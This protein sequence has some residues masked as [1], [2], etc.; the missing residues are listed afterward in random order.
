MVKLPSHKSNQKLM[1]ISKTKLLLIVTGS[2]LVGMAIVIVGA[3]TWLFL[4]FNAGN[5]ATLSFGGREEKTVD[6]APLVSEP[7]T[8]LGSQSVFFGERPA[9]STTVL[10]AGNSLIIGKTLVNEKPVQGVKLRLMLN[11]GVASQWAVSDEAGV[12]KISLPA[13]RYA[14]KGFELDWQTAN[15]TLAGKIM[16]PRCSGPETA[17]DITD[18]SPAKPG[19]GMDFLFIDPIEVLGPF[20]EQPADGKIVI[21]WRPY[22]N[23]ASYRVQLQEHVALGGGTVHYAFPWE[24][25][26]VVTSNSLDLSATGIKL[27]PQ[28]TYGIQVEA[29]NKE[30]QTISESP[31]RFRAPGFSVAGK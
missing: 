19:K 20:G 22:P 6:N 5:P 17:T 12:Y 14:T 15:R 11:G 26:P 28:V 13:G 18:A 25:R 21:A 29:L 23:A 2:V 30:G 1:E 4:K 24:T 9:E 7:R 16:D 31:D 8:Y 27:K 3:A 10:T